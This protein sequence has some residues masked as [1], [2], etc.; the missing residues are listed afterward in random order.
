MKYELSG[1]Q[2]RLEFDIFIEAI[3]SNKL[4]YYSKY[5]QDYNYDDKI[6]KRSNTDNWYDGEHK[7]NELVENT[8]KKL[9]LLK[10]K[11][12]L[13][14]EVIK[15]KYESG[16]REYERP[17]YIYDFLMTD[18]KFE[19]RFAHL[20]YEERAFCSLEI[21]FLM[22][23]HNIKVEA[24]ILSNIFGFEVTKQV[25]HDIRNDISKVL[26]CEIEKNHRGRYKIVKK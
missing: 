6:T 7:F 1:K 8:I 26:N 2:K 14:K 12:I 24:F 15:E 18:P 21:V 3:S 5:G 4:Q 20:S 19:Y 13:N 11:Y 17:H 9:K 10:I 22:M 25:F 16:F 23:M